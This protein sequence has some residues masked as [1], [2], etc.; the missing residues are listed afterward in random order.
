MIVFVQLEH[1][2]PEI[3]LHSLNISLD[4]KPC[5]TLSLFTQVYKWVLATYCRGY[6]VIDQLHPIQEG[7]AILLVTSC[8]VSCNGPTSHPGGSSNTPNHFMLQ[9][10]GLSPGRVDQIGS[11]ATLITYTLSRLESIPDLKLSKRNR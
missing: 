4:K 7:V 1:K 10:M 2:L 8:W 11:R 5:P 9:K 6:P 3:V